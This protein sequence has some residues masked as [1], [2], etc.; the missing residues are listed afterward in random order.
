MAS[1]GMCGVLSMMSES[2]GVMCY[3]VCVRRFAQ[4]LLCVIPSAMMAVGTIFNCRSC[5]AYVVQE[6]GHG[7]ACC[8]IR[9]MLWHKCKMQ[10]WHTNRHYCW[11][12]IEKYDYSRQADNVSHHFMKKNK[13]QCCP[14]SMDAL[15]LVPG[16]PYTTPSW[17]PPSATL[18]APQPAPLA[19]QIAPFDATSSSAPPSGALLAPQPPPSAA[20]ISPLGTS[21]SCF[22]AGSLGVNSLNVDDGEWYRNN[23]DEM[24][25]TIAQLRADIVSLNEKLRN[26]QV[27]QDGLCE[28]Q[29]LSFKRLKEV[30]GRLK[31]CEV[32]LK[33]P[34]QPSMDSTQP[35]MDSSDE[36]DSGVLLGS[37]EL[38]DSAEFVQLVEVA[39]SAMDDDEF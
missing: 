24:K 27:E 5:D 7:C 2:H 35:S 11:D 15:K 25:N 6:A 34:T 4:Q 37:V 22:R 19:T 9:E 3:H 12:C 38:G 8:D 1:L 39:D 13:T 18:P 26:M 28:V 17:A 32:Q 33:T 16:T 20:P 36:G 10:T 23:I 30:S 21:I 31:E 14:K 29:E